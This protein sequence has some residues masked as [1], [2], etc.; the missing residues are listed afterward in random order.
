MTAAS[1]ARSLERRRAF[2]LFWVMRLFTTA[3]AY[4]MLTVA[5]GWQIYDMTGS[6]LRSRFCRAGA[7]RAVR[8][9]RGR[10]RADRQPGR[11]ARHRRTCQI[12]KA[13]CTLVLA[14]RFRPKAALAREAIFA[15][16]FVIGTARVFETPT[17]HALLPALVPPELLARAIAASATANRPAVIGGPALGGLLYTSARDRGLHH[18]RRRLRDRQH[19][20]QSDP[21]RHRPAR[22]A[23]ISLA[24]SSPVSL[25]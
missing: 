9:A 16:L 12:V 1:A 19:A 2:A 14:V 4:F 13:T 8:A 5:V 3:P 7:I 17:L 25:L 22:E 15:V 24:V 21:A 11:P 18:L 6:A 23:A 20:R 10:G